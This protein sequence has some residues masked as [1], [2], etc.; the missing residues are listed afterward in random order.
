MKIVNIILT[1]QN[2]G[3]EQAFIDYSA[4]LKN[5]GHEVLAIVKDDAPY[6]DK[7]LQLDIKIK[8]ISNRFGYHDFLAVKKIQKILQEFEVD[9]VF[10]H[11]GR[12]MTLACKA[13]KKIKNRKIIFLAVNHSMNVKRSIGADIVLS[14][15]KEIFFRTINAGQSL[16]RSFVIHNGTDLSDAVNTVPQID[17]QKKP[18]I[19]IG[20]M[21]RLDEAKGFRFMV[22]AMKKL[23]EISSEKQKNFL[24]KISGTGQEKE[25]L[26]NLV[27]EL[28]IEDRVE[29]LGWTE[30]KSFFQSIDIFCMA[31]VKETFGLVLLEAMKYRKP[32]ISTDADGPKEILRPEID[33][34]LVKLNPLESLDQRLAEAILKMIDEPELAEKMIENSF[35]RL[36]DKFSYKALESRL[37]QIIGR[38]R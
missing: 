29:F 7:V 34:F 21:A 26:Q 31:S 38:M 4:V 22:R 36:N 14:V 12:S 37:E 15:N 11:A 30:K 5:L 18:V 13:I 35:V 10:A 8:K 27:K 33:G 19:V 23:A 25:F 6:A 2:G 3:A 32:I 20:V 16:D 1:S 24:L 17:L 28:Q 9:A